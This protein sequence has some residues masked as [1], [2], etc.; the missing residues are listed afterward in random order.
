[1]PQLG[2]FWESAIIL[3][4]TA[5]ADTRNPE[6]S[7]S[8]VSHCVPA[9]KHCIKGKSFGV[10]RKVF[11][12]ELHPD[13]KKVMD[14]AIKEMKR[15]GQPQDLRSV[16]AVSRSSLFQIVAMYHRTWIWQVNVS[17]NSSSF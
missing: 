11:F 14:N 10:P 12:D 7:L 15:R 13:T 2:L 17:A 4:V 16:L 8:P 1:M 5:S 9:L 3:E 6:S